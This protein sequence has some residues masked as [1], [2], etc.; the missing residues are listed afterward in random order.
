MANRIHGLSVPT[1]IIYNFN[2]PAYNMS[3]G[4]VAQVPENLLTVFRVLKVKEGE[5]SRVVSN[6]LLDQTSPERL[7]L[8]E[9]CPCQCGVALSLSTAVSKC[10]VKIPD[11]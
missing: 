7:L 3:A 5:Y 9:V 6:V 1:C 2:T 11:W 8:V 4:R 10:S